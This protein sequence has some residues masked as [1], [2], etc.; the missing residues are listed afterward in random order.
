MRDVLRSRAFLL[1]LAVKLVA[2]ACFGSHYATRWF[3]PFVHGFVSSGGDPWARAQ[4]AGELLAFPYGPTMLGVFGVAFAPAA[5]FDF[6]PGGPLSLFLLR[7]PLLAADLV[8]LACLVAWLGGRARDVVLVWWWNP[9]VLYASYVHGQLD[10]V[11]TALLVAAIFAIFRGRRFTGAALLG[12]AIGAKL[13]LLVALPL[14]AITLLRERRALVERAGPP[15]VAIL[16]AALA[17]LP[18]VAWSPAFVEMVFGTPQADRLFSMAISTGPGG[19][20]V[21]LAPAALLLVVLRFATM[22]RVDRVLLLLFVGLAYASLVALVPPMPGWFVWPAPFLAFHATRYSRSGW[23]ALLALSGAYLAYFLVSDPS[24]TLESLDPAFGGSFGAGLAARLA[25]VLPGVFSERAASVAYTVLVVASILACAELFV[26][27]IT[28]HPLYSFRSDAF[29]LGVAGDSA[30][31]KHTLARDLDSMLGSSRLTVL[32]GD[33]DH[34]W[35]RGDPHWSRY[36]HLD[37]RGNK[38]SEQGEKLQAIRRGERVESR[39]Y[40]H[41]TGRFGHVQG[42]AATEFVAIVGLHPFFLP[43]QREAL[44]LKVFLA[45]EE[46]DR[47]AW[48][49]ARDVAERGKQEHDVLAELDRREEDARKY[50]RPQR[51][52][53]DVVACAG[54]FDAAAPT[55]V[56]LSLEVDAS[57]GTLALWEHLAAIP[58]LIVEWEADEALERDRLRVSGTARAS[59]VFTAARA[60]RSSLDDSLLGGAEGWRDGTRG[61]MLLVVYH[62][63]V[64]KLAG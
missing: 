51:R 42:L 27:G 17:Y 59:D 1:G 23:Y 55:R 54:A 29:M 12:A 24:G 60:L 34:R 5:I 36:T 30:S 11:P 31:G 25:A 16:V 56:V 13:H 64:R 44:H 32:Y 15:L 18:L 28:R 52:R 57:I 49:L 3:A 10:L 9:V 2:A 37:P 35:E 8:V 21:L 20:S 6:A 22:R 33:D 53:A 62:S 46:G 61:V 58:G 4:A 40:D 19:P 63:I 7:L 39:P 43:A 14:V 47:R 41:G 50:V 26:R 38:L 45:P 48:K